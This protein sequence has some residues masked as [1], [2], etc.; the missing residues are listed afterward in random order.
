MRGESMKQLFAD[1]NA[2]KNPMGED[3]KYSRAIKVPQ[4][5]PSNTAPVLAEVYDTQK[6]NKL[7]AMINKSSVSDAEKSF[8]KFAATR[9]I[10]FNYAKIA[11]YYAHA[12]EEMQDLMEKSALVILDIDDAI[13]NGYVKLSAKMSQ[14]VD[15]AKKLSAEEDE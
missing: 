3:T 12:S 8:L 6:Y 11:D 2:K 7:I 10:V 1:E 4:Y 9:H 5:E 13:A 14:L 15:E